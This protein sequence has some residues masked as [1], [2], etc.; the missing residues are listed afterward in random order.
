[1]LD[2]VYDSSAARRALDWRPRHD[3]RT[4]LARIAGGGSVLSPLA[5]EI[6]IKGYHR[7]R[8]ADGLYP[9]SE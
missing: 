3:F 8:Y 9:V 6:G 7:D 1:R 5:R 4:V 2:R